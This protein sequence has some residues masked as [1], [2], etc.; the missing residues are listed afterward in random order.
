MCH[1]FITLNIDEP[2]KHAFP[3]RSNSVLERET[4]RKVGIQILVE[5][6]FMDQIGPSAKTGP[7]FEGLQLR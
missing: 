7:A 1:A 5:I 6:R 2:A 3:A 4:I